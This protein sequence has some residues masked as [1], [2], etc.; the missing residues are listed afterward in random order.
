MN[1]TKFR[2]AFLLLSLLLIARAVAGQAAQTQFE[3]QVGQP[4]KDVVWVPTGQGLVEKMLDLASFCS[5][6]LESTLGVGS[7]SSPR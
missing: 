6:T 2:Q 1:A 4:G 7:S 3:P 5:E